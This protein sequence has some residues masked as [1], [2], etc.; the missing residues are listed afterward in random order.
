MANSSAIVAKY[1]S[2]ALGSPLSGKLVVQA[3]IALET[4]KCFPVRDGFEMPNPPE[5]LIR[6]RRITTEAESEPHIAQVR[7]EAGCD[8]ER[9]CRHN[10]NSSPSALVRAAASFEYRVAHRFSQGLRH[11]GCALR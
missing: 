3:L 11:P 7:T 5:I 8:I 9:S 10:R 6:L 2:P 1:G 4:H